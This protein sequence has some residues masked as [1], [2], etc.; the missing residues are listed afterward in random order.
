[1]VERMLNQ[2]TYDELADDFKYFE[3]PTDGPDSQKGS[4]LPL[5]RFEYEKAKRL[6]VTSMVWC[7]QTDN[8]DLMVVSFGSYDFSKQG[9]GYLIFYSLKN[10]SYPECVIPCDEGIMSLAVNPNKG[11]LIAC[12]L[13]NGSVSIFNI[14]ENKHTHLF[15][16][17][18]A[19]HSEPIWSIKWLDND[20]EDRLRFCSIATD[21]KVLQWTLSKN[22]LLP[23]TLL[24]LKNG[25]TLQ[26]G[27][28]IDFHPR[29]KSSYLCGTEEGRLF[30]CST[31]YS[32]QYIDEFQA[33]DGAIMAVK[34]N[35]FHP[36]VF[37]TA[38]QD[39]S[40]KIWSNERGAAPLFNF[41]LGA[42]VNDIDWAPYSS[43]VIVAV[44]EGDNG[45]A[46][47]YDLAINKHQPLCDQAVSQ[48]KRTRLTQ[49]KI[50]PKHRIVVVGND[51]GIVSSFK[52]SPNLRK[53]PLKS[54]KDPT[55]LPLDPQKEFEKLKKVLNY[56]VD[57]I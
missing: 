34:W 32:T 48:K 20:V 47:V 4:L 18:P 51:R 49:I 39:W 25:N 22:E 8:D 43:T 46:F 12:G 26:S 2:N 1:V 40:L 7:P 29:D 16:S 55:P 35:Q 17:S 5:W 23:S 37:A 56:M 53:V 57:E 30:K 14:K 28:C 31:K 10:P 19:K 13:Y 50:N 27:M 6:S 36:D 9:K 24:E 42:P 44:T 33:H 15:N 54:K 3:D 45:K 11:F 38:S 41:E 21:G 52:L